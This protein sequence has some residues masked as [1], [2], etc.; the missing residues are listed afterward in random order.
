MGLEQYL[1]G[2]VLLM[3]NILKLNNILINSIEDDPTTDDVLDWLYYF[4][5]SVVRVNGVYTF[6]ISSLNIGNIGNEYILKSDDLVL[7][8]TEI[9]SMW[10]RRGIL[11]MLPNLKSND[12]T[13]ISAANYHLSELN[14]V[15][16]AV[17]YIEQDSFYSINKYTD[18]KTN[19]LINLIEARRAGLNIPETLISNDNDSVVNFL[20][21]HD[22]IVIKPISRSFFQVLGICEKEVQISYPTMKVDSTDLLKKLKDG[23]IKYYLP[24]LFQSYIEKR[25][26]I[27]CFYIMGEF[28]SMAIFSQQNEKTKVDFRNYDFDRPNRTIPYKLPK[29]IEDKL[30]T[31]LK[32]INLN[33]GSIDIILTP[34]G[35]YFFLEVNPVG[36]FQWLSR[37]C[38]YYIERKIA[39]LLCR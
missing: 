30:A 8:R 5:E 1:T 12:E 32:A 27:R 21:C 37:N 2:G 7:D 14:Y 18:N 9:K 17:S 35:E 36:Q 23:D 38:N 6:N 20:N 39:K 4:G 13:L 34:K 15:M 29:E 3:N 19:K 16:D 28:Y 33:C 10:Y 25:Y 31:L 24:T 11:S 22:T 26:E